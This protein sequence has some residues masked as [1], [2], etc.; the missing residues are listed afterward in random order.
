VYSKAGREIPTDMETENQHTGELLSHHLADRSASDNFRELTQAG[1]QLFEA[2]QQLAR[3]LNELQ[4]RMEHATD[5]KAQL[6]E[7]PWLIAVVALVGGIVGWRFFTRRH[8]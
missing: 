6:A 2:G 7:R 3:N 8:P 4:R 5:L 1:K